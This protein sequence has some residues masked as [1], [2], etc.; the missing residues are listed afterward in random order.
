MKLPVRNRQFFYTLS[1]P[2]TCFSFFLTFPI[3]Q[4]LVENC[5]IA[6]PV[7]SKRVKVF[8]SSGVT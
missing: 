2:F 6:S 8:S 3:T 1:G 7:K 5:G 4:C